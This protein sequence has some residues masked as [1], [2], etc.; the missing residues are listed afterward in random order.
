[1]LE[2]GQAG[3][4]LPQQSHGPGPS[5]ALSWILSLS[6][7]LFSVGRLFQEGGPQPGHW[8]GSPPGR[9]QFLPAVVSTL[10][11]KGQQTA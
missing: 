4:S 5:R 2:Q 10:Q 6:D 3:V 8:G 11:S 1:M 9:A 7:D